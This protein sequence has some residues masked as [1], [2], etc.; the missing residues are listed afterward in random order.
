MKDEVWDKEVLEN[1]SDLEKMKMILFQ[2]MIGNWDWQFPSGKSSYS[3]NLYILRG[4][5]GVTRA[6]PYDFDLASIVTGRILRHYP[7][8]Y[9][10]GKTNFYK[11]IYY[12]LDQRIKEFDRSIFEEIKSYFLTKEFVVKAAPESYPLDEDGRSN[13][14]VHIE[15]FYQILR[16]I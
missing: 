10:P 2:A 12:L 1:Y 13:I 3:H 5:D 16:D 9:Q 8:G 7:K 15:V 11:N 4:S 6:V 14:Q